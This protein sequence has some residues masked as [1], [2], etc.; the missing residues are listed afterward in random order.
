[1][2]R[3]TE[4]VKRVCYV[5]DL[6]V[7]ATGVKISDLYDSI[8][9]YLEEITAYLDNSLLISVPMSTVTLFSS[10]PHQSKNE[11]EH[12]LKGEQQNRR[13]FTNYKKAA[14]TKFTEDI[15]SAFAQNT[16]PTNIEFSQT[17]F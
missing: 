8:N 13:T 17:S 14:W 5:D 7:W 2:P 1:M 12:G 15:E 10:D 3:P 6:T 11:H 16:K 9:S 4:P